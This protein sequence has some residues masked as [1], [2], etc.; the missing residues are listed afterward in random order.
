[1]ARPKEL[2]TRNK[3]IKCRVT[4][5]EKKAI[6]LSADEAGLS[7][8]DFVRKC[9]MNKKVRLRFTPEEMETYAML[10]K[11]HDNFRRISNLIKNNPHVTEE[12]T[13]EVKEVQ[14][15]IYDHLKQFS[16]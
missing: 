10:H 4:P 7:L 12:L 9:A 6:E 8:S 15:L 13:K 1:M 2:V 3:E 5:L 14:A 16:I 11:Y